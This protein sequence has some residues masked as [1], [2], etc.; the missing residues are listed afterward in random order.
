ML[1]IVVRRIVIFVT[2]AIGLVPTAP[3]VAQDGRSYNWTGLYFGAHGQFDLITYDFALFNSST[4]RFGGGLHAGY[5]LQMG[6]V[7]FG[8]VADVTA[9]DGVTEAALVTF[10][11]RLG[12]DFGGAMLYA[13]AGVA[14]SV[15]AHGS[16]FEQFIY[17]AGLSFKF[18]E[19]AS[20]TAEWLQTRDQVGDNWV[21]NMY[22]LGVS[23]H[24]R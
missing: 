13:T 3:A 23:Y 10:R 24:L 15:G 2:M 11:G 19:K 8:G 7:V 16:D 12:Y 20:F 14:G 5:N 6:S 22:R 1:G 9:L 18:S 4:S 21:Y 17:G